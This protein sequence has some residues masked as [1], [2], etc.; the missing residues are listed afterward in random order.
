MKPIRVLDRNSPHQDSGSKARRAFTLIELLV[1][2]AI[3]AILAALLLPA[4]ASAKEKATRTHCVSNLHQIGIGIRMYA[5]DYKDK[6]PFATVGSGDWMWDLHPTH[7]D[8]LAA[9]VVRKEVLYCPGNGGKYK[10]EQIKSWWN[11]SSGARRVTHYG[12][13]MRRSTGSGS[14][15]PNSALTGNT[16]TA[17]DGK[18]F[19]TTFNT[20]NLVNTELVVDVVITSTPTSADFVRVSSTATGIP[21]FQGYHQSSHIARNKALG[22]EILFMDLHVDWRKLQFMKARY[23]YNGSPWWWF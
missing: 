21:G 12:W 7:A 19:L 11:Y 3:I 10:L 2:I 4:L 16:G 13:L 22:G 15:I 18:R 14:L 20:T 6:L 17:Q 23:S 9:A 1:V 8:L 5:D